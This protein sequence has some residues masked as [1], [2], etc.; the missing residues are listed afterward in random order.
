MPRPWASR[1]GSMMRMYDGCFDALDVEGL[2]SGFFSKQWHFVKV[3]RQILAD[4]T[5]L[6]VNRGLLSGLGEAPSVIKGVGRTKHF[7]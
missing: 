1:T 5:T 3:P 7:T 4:P 6:L 2:Y